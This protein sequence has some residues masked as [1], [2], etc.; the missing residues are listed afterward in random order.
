MVG[1]GP[2]SLIKAIFLAQ[3][4]PNDQIIIIDS[5][6][7]IGGAWFTDQSPSGYDIESGCHIWTYVPE[8]YEFIEKNLGIKLYPV[9]PSP[10]FVGGKIRLPYTLKN[11]IDSYKTVSKLLL[12][13]KWNQIK[14][15]KKIP[16][17][18]TK[19]FINEIN[20]HLLVQ[21]N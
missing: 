15:L 21:P 18:N 5:A 3:E 7:K 17:F 12:K 13:G 10:V 11:T 8:A 2:C 1:S 20:T 16:V 19:F 4:N 14:K 6:S 9:A